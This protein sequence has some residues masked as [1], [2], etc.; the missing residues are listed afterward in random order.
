MSNRK[1]VFAILFFLGI[2]L[3]N[4]AVLLNA[5]NQE[6][7]LVVDAF[8]Q[9]PLADGDQTYYN[10]KC[11]I[12]AEPEPNCTIDEEDS[13]CTIYKKTGNCTSGDVSVK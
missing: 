11:N 6:N 1:V 13:T 4:V 10:V 9:Q 8:D 2:S 5:S 12:S 7:Q 3:L